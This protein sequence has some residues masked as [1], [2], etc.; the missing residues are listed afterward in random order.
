MA[1]TQAAE[2]QQRGVFEVDED[3]ALATLELAGSGVTEAGTWRAWMPGPV[4]LSR[5]GHVL[6]GVARKPRE[7]PGA[8]GLRSADQVL[9]GARSVRNVRRS[10]RDGNGIHQGCGTIRVF[11]P[12]ANDTL[13]EACALPAAVTTAWRASQPVTG[14]SR[15]PEQLLYQP[16]AKRRAD[17]EAGLFTSPQAAHFHA[18]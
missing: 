7:M 2:R 10:S 9:G 12:P 11:R 1:A 8:A 18:P 13:P 14:A 5:E 17:L 3:R 16:T 6:A 4:L 15:D